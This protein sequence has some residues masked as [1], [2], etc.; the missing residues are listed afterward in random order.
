MLIN[1]NSGSRLPATACASTGQL[2]YDAG[3]QVHRAQLSGGRVRS[4]RRSVREGFRRVRHR[5]RWRPRRQQGS[6]PR[7]EAG[8]SADSS[9]SASDCSSSTARCAIRLPTSPFAGCATTGVEPAVGQSR[10]IGAHVLAQA[11]GARRGTD[12]TEPL[13]VPEG[14]RPD[15]AEAILQRG[16]RTAAAARPSR[17]PRRARAARDA[18]GRSRCTAKR[19]RAPADADCSEQEP[20]PGQA[21][22][23]PLRAFLERRVGHR[24][25]READA[26]ADRRDVVEVVVDA[27]ELEQQRPRAAQLIVGVQAERR[28]AGM[29]V[30]DR[31]RD[32]AGA[33]CALRRRRS[34][35][36]EAG[37]WPPPRARGACR[38]AARRGAG[39]ARRRRGSESARTRSRRRGSGR[40]RP[41]GCRD[42]RPGRSRHRAARGDPPVAAAVRGRRTAGRG[43]SAASRSSQAAAGISSTMLSTARA[44]WAADDHPRGRG[45]AEHR[46]Q[47]DRVGVARRR[48]QALEASRRP[49]RRPGTRSASRRRATSSTDDRVATRHTRGTASRLSCHAPHQRLHRGGAREQVGARR[50]R[51]QARR[52]ST[53]VSRSAS[54]DRASAAPAAARARRRAGLRS[55]RA[56]VRGTRGRAAPRRSAS[57]PACP[58]RCP[59]S[60]ISSSLKNS[61]EGGSATERP[62][63]DPDRGGRSGACPGEA[64]R[65]ARRRRRAG[66]AAAASRRRSRAPW[67]ARG[68]RGAARP[69]RSPAASQ[70]RSRARA[71]PCAR[72]S[73]TRAAAS[74]PSAA[75]G[76]AP[77]SRA[78]RARTR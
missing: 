10:A 72:G 69:R 56:R 2:A 29:R 77:R 49:A 70:T 23:E 28:L 32:R 12:G 37:R 74:T 22:I 6:P 8:S 44:R 65:C 67:R 24:S 5:S 55:A 1:G 42:R 48:E 30:G 64:V 43:V 52:R 53:T 60:R 78:T 68:R 58:P 71:R 13:G 9:S 20:V 76:T 73:S 35:H 3:S 36:S 21:Q 62:E 63:A 75:T 41:G 14:E 45:R 25:R 54:A 7:A 61:G 16:R 34:R 46:A 31:V 59:P 15:L 18:H 38:T 27:L 66:V 19:Q 51:D 17:A 50:Q 33:A 47:L 4:G 39:S 40:R 57:R 11:G 26:G